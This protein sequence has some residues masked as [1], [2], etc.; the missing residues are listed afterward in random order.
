MVRKSV[1]DADEELPEKFIEEFCTKAVFDEDGCQ[2]SASIGKDG[3]EYGDELPLEPPVNYQAPPTL[4]EMMRRMIQSEEFQRRARD[5]GW[6]TMEEASD[7]EIDDDGEFMDMETAYEVL[8]RAINASKPGPAVPQSSAEPEGGSG[9]AST[10]K[11]PPAEPAK[12]EST[13][14]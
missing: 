3:K 2:V 9:G 4:M 10:N 13:S 6:D 12:P 5:A 7:Y 1:A 8:G 11:A 14:T